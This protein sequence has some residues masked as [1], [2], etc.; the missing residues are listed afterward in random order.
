MKIWCK[1]KCLVGPVALNSRKWAQSYYHGSRDLSIPLVD[2]N[3]FYGG[4]ASEKQL[5]AAQVIAALR[6][7]GCFH[8]TG[9]SISEDQLANALNHSSDIFNPINSV[10]SKTNSNRSHKA[11][12]SSEDDIERTVLRNLYSSWS[13]I[14]L[15]STDDDAD[16]TG[17]YEIV[18]DS[19][20]E[21]GKDQLSER[22]GYKPIFFKFFVDCHML[23]LQIMESIAIGF[24]LPKDFFVPSCSEMDHTLRLVRHPSALSHTAQKH[25][26]IPHNDIASMTIHFQNYRGD[27]HLIDSSGSLVQAPLPLPGV[28]TVTAGSLLRRWSNDMFAS[29]Q[30]CAMPPASSVAD[31]AVPVASASA[32]LVCRPNLDAVIQCLHGCSGPGHPRRHA[33][34][35]VRELLGRGPQPAQAM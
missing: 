29:P 2:F 9:H 32:A 3:G 13:T 16:L 33:D 23:H 14:S 28:A 6:S 27:L 1:F 10:K 30:I 11:M 26:P 18:A 12:D 35:T 8:I 19:V 22:P 15:P 25:G 4:I 17:S 20:I 7:V 24:G 21:V 5:T 34:V 31:G